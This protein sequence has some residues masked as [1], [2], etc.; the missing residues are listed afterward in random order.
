MGFPYAFPIYFVRMI[1]LDGRYAAATPPVNAVLVIGRD[2]QGNP[3]QGGYIHPA[4]PGRVGT[5]YDFIYDSCIPTAAQAGSIAAAQSVRMRLQGKPGWLRVPQH[6][7]IEMYDV[8]G[9][10][11]SARSQV[12]AYYRITA[13]RYDFNPKKKRYQ[14]RL[15]LSSV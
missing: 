7:G 10:A 1:L 13:I 2:V 8:I 9:V 12:S 5:Q 4:E 6:C 3:V 11:D 14:Q 15:T